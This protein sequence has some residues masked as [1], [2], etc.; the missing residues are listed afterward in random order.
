MNPGAFSRRRLRLCVLLC[1]VPAASS[2][3]MLQPLLSPGA[4]GIQGAFTF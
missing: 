1:V 3:L 4:V 2:S